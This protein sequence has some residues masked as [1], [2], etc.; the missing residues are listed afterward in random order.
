MGKAQ[1][2]GTHTRGSRE[3]E[4]EAEY[5]VR[6]GRTGALSNTRGTGEILF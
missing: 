3:K 2:C 5:A 1:E 6:S 4:V